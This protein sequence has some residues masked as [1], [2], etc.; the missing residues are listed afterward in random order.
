MPGQNAWVNSLGKQPGKQPGKMQSAGQNAGQ[1]AWANSLGKQPGQRMNRVVQPK[2][3][4]LVIPF[5]SARCWEGHVGILEPFALSFL[6]RH[7][8]AK[9]HVQL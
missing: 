7:F 4:V 3:R 6:R 5:W 9:I 8:M 1:T 2:M